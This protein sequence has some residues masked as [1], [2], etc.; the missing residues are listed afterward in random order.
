MAIVPG[1]YDLKYRRI[2]VIVKFGKLFHMLVGK[3]EYASQISVHHGIYK[4][5]CT[6]I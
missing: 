4:C 2:F 6:Y 5:M 1:N 3:G